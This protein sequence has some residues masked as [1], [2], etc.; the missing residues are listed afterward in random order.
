MREKVIKT[1]ELDMVSIPG[2]LTP[3]EILKA[4][5]YGAD[6]VKL[7]P[8]TAMGSEYVKAIKAP[9]SH[10]DFLAVGGIDEKNISE[11][12]K[13]GVCGFGIGSN[14]ADKNLIASKNY[15]GLTK[16]AEKYTREIGK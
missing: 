14:I 15:S 13:A 4:H 12:L 10:I 5:N 3:T 8:V 16:L 1:R 2:A 9:L 7:F 11:Y 6:F